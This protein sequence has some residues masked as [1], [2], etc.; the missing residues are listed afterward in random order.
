MKFFLVIDT[1]VFVSALLSKNEES[2]TVQVVNMIFS[3]D[4]VFLY[5]KEIESEYIEVLNREKFHFSK[6]N[7]DYLLGAIRKYGLEVNPKKLNV[8]L[9]DMKD[10]PFY[11]VV[12]EKKDD[13]AYLVT[14]NI[15]HF[16]KDPFVVT[17]RELLS[18]LNEN[19]HL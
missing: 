11:E 2:A 8:L 12:Y 19:K 4:V 15:R 6:K 13:N 5:S 16:P 3:D 18:I 10:M 17:P 14:G 9:P 1:N 7:T